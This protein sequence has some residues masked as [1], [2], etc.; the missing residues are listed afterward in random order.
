MRV[1]PG[2]ALILLFGRASRRGR[3]IS[4]LL[5]K[6]LPLRV[7]ES[8]VGASNEG[9]G[10]MENEYQYEDSLLDQ[11][12]EDQLQGYQQKHMHQCDREISVATT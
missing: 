9:P 7:V 10:S 3:S 8:T 1:G 6:I 12:Q 2:A 4:A 11:A 5:L